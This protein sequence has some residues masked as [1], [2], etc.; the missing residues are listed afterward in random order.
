MDRKIKI[1]YLVDTFFV[2]GAEKLVLDLA[3]NLAPDKFEVQAA[4]VICGGPL[5][6][7]FE[8]LGIAVKVF[9]KKSNLGLE[10]IWPIYK[11]LK[12]SQPDI[13]HTHLFGADTW[14]R[15]AAI[16][17]RVP[18]IIS[19]EHN[20]N[21]NQNRLKKIIK[22][23]LSWFTAEIIA[24]SFGVKDYAHKIEKI[25]A[26][27]IEVIYNGIDLQKFIWRGYQPIKTDKIEAITV[28]RLAEQKGQ[29]YLIEAL[30]FI[31]Q[32]YP[33]F[34]LNIIGTGRL[35]HHLKN[36]AQSLGVF[37]HIKMWGERSDV[38]QILSTMD[39][40]ILP[41]LWEGLGLVILEA[42]AV[43]LPVLAC[44][45]PGV[46]EVVIDNQTGLLFSPK[47]PRAISQAVA[48]IISQPELA[49]TV[50]EQSRKQVEAK[51]ALQHMVSAYTN[52]YLKL[53]QNH[54]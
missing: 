32:E 24:V 6:E 40:F 19:T 34:K 35:E 1:V 54:D 17:A 16:L 27:K 31:L 46:E 8:K 47:D 4:A 50:V 14:G 36:L 39:I 20:I 7:D 29:Q 18:V 2:G 38:S 11:Y 5:R 49:K 13:V 22:L 41:S 51:F 43:G 26:E 10:L 37:D 52:L 23:I 53:T 44:K 15:I 48:K 12:A 3:K 9:Y 28:G 33:N 45:I 30:P 21:L 42:Q 25:K